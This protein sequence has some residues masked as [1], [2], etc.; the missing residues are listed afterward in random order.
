MLSSSWHRTK[1]KFSRGLGRSEAEFLMA[2]DGL[3]LVVACS[4]DNNIAEF[5]LKTLEVTKQELG[6]NPDGLA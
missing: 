3:C 5:E 2:P 6:R 4:A 1:L